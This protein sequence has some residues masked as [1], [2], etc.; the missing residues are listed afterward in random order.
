M[1]KHYNTR[2]SSN[3]K[4][5]TDSKQEQS[6][7]RP[8]RDRSNS[9]EEMNKK[10]RNAP[11]NVS[12]LPQR[13]SEEAQ[14][15]ID[16]N[17]KRLRSGQPQFTISST[18]ESPGSPLASPLS[19][20]EIPTDHKKLST[21]DYLLSRRNRR[22][23]QENV[24]ART[25]NTANL[26]STNETDI[27]ISPSKF[28]VCSENTTVSPSK[29]KKI[30]VGTESAYDNEGN[31]TNIYFRVNQ[32]RADTKIV[33]S[34]GDHTIAHLM[35][36]DTILHSTNLSIKSAI[37]SFK[38]LAKNILSK[39][40]LVGFNKIIATP[41]H[42]TKE[43]REVYAL[44]EGENKERQALAKK[45]NQSMKNDKILKFASHLTQLVEY[46]L[47][48]VQKEKITTS[49]SKGRIQT[50]SAQGD[51]VKGASRALV[52]LNKLCKLCNL[53][54]N[55]FKEELEYFISSLRKNNEDSRNEEECVIRHGLGRWNLALQKQ[56]GENK[57]SKFKEPDTLANQLEEDSTE[58][59]KKELLKGFRD[60]LVNQQDVM[61]KFMGDLIDYHHKIAFHISSESLKSKRRGSVMGVTKDE[62]VENE[63][64]E[65]EGVKSKR[66]PTLEQLKEEF[67]EITHTIIANQNNANNV[68]VTRKEVKDLCL[69]L[70]K[71]KKLISYAFA[72]LKKELDSNNIFDATFENFIETEILEKQGWKELAFKNS[73]TRKMAGLDKK[74]ILH[75]MSNLL[76]AQSDTSPD[77]DSDREDDTSALPSRSISPNESTPTL[78]SKEKQP[79]Q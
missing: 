37:E 38:D 71:Y 19:T 15:P 55:D 27:D 29:A 60:N 8:R 18:L 54:G 56:E 28:S 41:T 77:S 12:S 68:T 3:A 42:E 73:I 67:P 76:K 58:I 31:I 78:Q 45:V 22:L 62:E 70:I 13:S 64:V 1:S 32:Q 36:V 43:R 44:V 53:E 25:N 52:M 6:P 11:N 63:V 40:E 35:I 57:N 47:T 16:Q 59:I 79:H 26:L 5:E 23:T 7:E 21:Q 20:S 39:G 24:E 49:Y 4:T 33:N 51:K 66:F 10:P 14:A 2:S 65:N 9:P 61:A 69:I 75:E 46:F 74:D 30:L 17:L 72:D 48:S 34:Q 50:D